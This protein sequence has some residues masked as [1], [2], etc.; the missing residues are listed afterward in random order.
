[1][2]II[3]F[4]FGG[5]VIGAA[6]MWFGIRTGIKLAAKVEDRERE[7]GLKIANIDTEALPLEQINTDGTIEQENTQDV[8]GVEDVL[9]DNRA[10]LFEGTKL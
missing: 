7:F 3:L 8:K 6:L 4:S 5:L 10:D 9:P 1:M 2:T